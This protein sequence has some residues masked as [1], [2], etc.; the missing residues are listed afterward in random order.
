MKYYYLPNNLLEHIFVFKLKFVGK[1]F[2]TYLIVMWLLK[3]MD[4][5]QW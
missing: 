5:V 1:K 3:K 4:P 2:M